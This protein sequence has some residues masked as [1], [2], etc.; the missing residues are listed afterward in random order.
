MLNAIYNLINLN[1]LN[2][3]V[4]Q[5]HKIALNPVSNLKLNKVFLLK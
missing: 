5:N 2:A 1:K 3:N 4:K